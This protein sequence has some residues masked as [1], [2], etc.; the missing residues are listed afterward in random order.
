MKIEMIYVILAVTILTCL[1][2]PSASEGQEYEFVLSWPEILGLESPSGVAVDNSGNLYVADTINNRINRIQKF[3][4]AGNFLMKWGTEGIDHGQFYGS[5]GI[6]VDSSGNVYVADTDHRIQ[7]FD[8]D[9]NFL[10]KWGTKG[11]D[12]GQ[13]YRPS[14]IAV[15]GSGNVFVADTKNGRIQKFRLAGIIPPGK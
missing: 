7:K 4:S 13:F 8:S 5:S 15:D 6:A 14:G 12:H 2:Y 9:G 1:W 10:M 3:D 11:S